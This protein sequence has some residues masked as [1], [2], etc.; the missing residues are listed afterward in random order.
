MWRSHFLTACLCREIATAIESDDPEELYL[1]GLM[2]NIGELFLLRVL[3]EFF[4]KQNNQLP[5]A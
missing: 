1:M 4:Q 3:G 5:D 2:H